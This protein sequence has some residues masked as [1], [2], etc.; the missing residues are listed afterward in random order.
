MKE[1]RLVFYLAIDLDCWLDV[2]KVFSWDLLKEFYL[3]FL[4]G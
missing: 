3:G 2:L 1:M 4:L